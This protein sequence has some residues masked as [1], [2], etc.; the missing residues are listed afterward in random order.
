[1]YNHCSSK[2]KKPEVVA[3]VTGFESKLEP[4]KESPEDLRIR[5]EILVD[6]LQKHVLRALGYV[7]GNEIDQIMLTMEEHPH[8]MEHLKTGIFFFRNDSLDA[9]EQQIRTVIKGEPIKL[10][11]F[12]NGNKTIHE[13]I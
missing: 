12:L 11:Q 3:A 8:V 1:M 7:G 13:P 6:P 4:F 2:L 5:H 9:A 10:A